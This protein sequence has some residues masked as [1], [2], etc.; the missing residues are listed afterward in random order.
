[1]NVELKNLR[2]VAVDGGTATGKGRLIDELAQL[3][4]LKGVP[5]IHISTGS[6]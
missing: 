3:L 4:R 6:I 2:V 1:M 5:V